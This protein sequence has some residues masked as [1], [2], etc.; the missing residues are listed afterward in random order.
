L[1]VRNRSRYQREDDG[2]IEL[3]TLSEATGI[4]HLFMDTPV[5]DSQD[6]RFQL[7]WNLMQNDRDLES[8][9]SSDGF[10]VC[11]SNIPPTVI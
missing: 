9:A 2:F 3:N 7:G 10:S 8:V 5:Q 6:H 1:F 4:I 11:I